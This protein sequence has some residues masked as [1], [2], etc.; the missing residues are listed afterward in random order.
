MAGDVLGSSEVRL[1]LP[2]DDKKLRE[3]VDFLKSD[4][5]KQKVLLKKQFNVISAAEEIFV[6]ISNYAYETKG[7]VEIA[8]YVQDGTYY[9]RF[10][11]KGK[12]YNPLEH[13]DPDVTVDLKDRPIGGLGIFLAKEFSDKISYAYKDGEN[14][15]TI[16]VDL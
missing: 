6:N 7:Y 1:T 3:L 8:T 14:I 15:L 10:A 12:K 9:V 11:D 16:G 13:K 2:A 4:M 5:D